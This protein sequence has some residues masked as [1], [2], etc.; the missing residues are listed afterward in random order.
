MTRTEFLNQLRIRLSTIPKD[1][2]DKVIE[3]YSEIINDK[4]DEGK[5][6][7]QAVAEL[8][9]PEK[10]ANNALE[11]YEETSQAHINKKKQHSVGAIIG[12][13]A[14]IPFVCIAM[15]VLGTLVI[16]FLAASAGMIVGGV[17]SI[18]SCFIIF[19][20]SFSV[21]L[22]QLG[23]GAL[24]LGLG[25][26]ALYGS[27]AFS[28]LYIRVMKSIIKKYQSVYGGVEK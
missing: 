14:L 5:T 8:D 22:F 26:F 20:Q 21:G 6:E 10:I 2:Q 19:V 13:S 4:I 27:I 1:E 12:F 24:I 11:D 18:I 15:V 28:K 23:G 25:V 9:S 17:C 3:Y 16:S 7:E